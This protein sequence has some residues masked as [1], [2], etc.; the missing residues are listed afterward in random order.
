MT[1]LAEMVVNLTQTM[2]QLAV[3]VATVLETLNTGVV[4]KKRKETPSDM[5]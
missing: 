4:T 5:V 2:E 1:E 3:M